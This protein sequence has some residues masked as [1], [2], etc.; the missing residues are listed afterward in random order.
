MS[1]AVARGILRHSAFAFS[2]SDASAPFDIRE[3]VSHGRPLPIL[4]TPSVRGSARRGFLCPEEPIMR[5]T[6]RAAVAA[7]C[8]SAPTEF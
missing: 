4:A 5:N 2:G 6:I 1:R 3:V 8:L 7:A